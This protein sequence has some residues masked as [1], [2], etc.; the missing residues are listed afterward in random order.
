MIPSKLTL[1]GLSDEPVSL[2][3]KMNREEFIDPRDMDEVTAESDPRRREMRRS[4][5]T[6]YRK[7]ER[8]NKGDPVPDLSLERLEE[9]GSVGLSH[10]GSR[11]AVLIFGSY[12]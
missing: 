6:T 1:L 11:P 3:K 7:E 2:E 10:L 12:T 8:L 9:T 5:I 4:T